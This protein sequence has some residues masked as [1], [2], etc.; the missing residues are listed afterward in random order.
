LS[1]CD[2]ALRNALDHA[3]RG[4]LEVQVLR[5]Q[6][7]DQRGKLKVAEALPPGYVDRSL[8]RPAGHARVIQR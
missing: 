7:F 8:D 6:P 3:F 4:G 2:P 1:I 5:D